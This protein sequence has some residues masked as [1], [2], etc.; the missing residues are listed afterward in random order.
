MSAVATS[1]RAVPQRRS[2][3]SPTRDAWNRYRRNRM[4]LVGGALAIVI[5]L[6][7]ILAPVLAT[8]AYDFSDL[9][10]TLKGPSAQHLLGVDE[11]G[12]DIF[13]RLVYGAR[14]SMTVGIFVPMIGAL[15]GMPLGA[16]AGWFGHAADFITLRLVEAAT[17]VP[18]L[19]V[20]LLLIAIYG[21]GLFHVTIFLGVVS[22]VNFARLTRAQFIALRDR[23]FVTAARAI[24]TPNWRIMV[25]HILPNALGPI[26]VLFILSIPGAVFAEAGYSF[27]GLGVQDPVPSW[28][29]MITEGGQFMRIDPLFA[30]LP[31]LMIALT[32]LSF[33]FLGDGLRD[34]LD[35]NALE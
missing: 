8:Q 15:I 25:Q 29:K 34:A 30:L 4:A 33:S 21:S 16:V 9:A 12:R 31:I 13:S 22:W 10:Q 27:L 17:A 23:E 1:A 24:G 11:V 19:L 5:L 18:A 6:T 35:P 28:G 2:K 26:I 7:A 20:G 3:S 32:M 14:T